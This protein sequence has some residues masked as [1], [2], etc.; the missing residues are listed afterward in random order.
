[1]EEVEDLE[2]DLDFVSDSVLD[3]DRDLVHDDLDLVELLVLE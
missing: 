2:L 3:L 1:M